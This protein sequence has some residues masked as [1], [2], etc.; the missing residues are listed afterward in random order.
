LENKLRKRGG[1]ETA[2]AGEEEENQLFTT[3]LHPASRLHMAVSKS[4]G[5]W[6][7]PALGS[8]TRAYSRISSLSRRYVNIC[9]V[10]ECT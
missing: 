3:W 4:V 8:Y 1:S 9:G 5:V 6:C 7:C 10:L 2:G